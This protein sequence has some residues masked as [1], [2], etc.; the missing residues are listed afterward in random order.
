MKNSVATWLAAVGLSSNMAGPFWSAI[1]IL[2]LFLFCFIAHRLVVR[3]A[4]P[5]VV[6]AI[7][8]SK[9][10]MDDAILQYGV[11]PRLALLAPLVLFYT[12]LDLI[13]PAGQGIG[14]FGRRTAMVLFILVSVSTIARLLRAIHD[15]L[16]TTDFGQKRPLR[17]Y[18]DAVRITIFCLATI[19]AF[20]TITGTPPWG[21]LSFL[22]GFTVLLMLVFKDTILG[23]VASI[24]ISLNDTVRMGDWIQM[25]QF[26]ADGEIIDISIHA[27]KV[28][29]WDKTISV[30]PSYALTSQSF[31]NWRGMSES[32]G[33]RIKRSILIDITSIH[34]CNEELLA[35]LKKIFLLKDYLAGR[36]AEIEQY[37]AAVGADPSEPVNGRRLTNIGTFRAYVVAYL[38][39]HPQVHQEM[40]F[41]VR[42]LPPG[43]NGLPLEIYIFSKDQVWANYEAIQADIFD[44]LLAVLPRFDLRPFQNPT[45]MDFRTVSH[46]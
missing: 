10:T 25:D 44:H 14:E 29:N 45:G 22:G 19:F 5:L 9:T 15:A 3:L 7:R 38:R 32:G 42:H 24:Q 8:F 26:G 20:S 41:L 13:F 28:Q 11:L 43:P 30:I 1:L 21:I 16:R 35:R 2:L 23:F 27:V 17:G 31:K 34:F 46:G 37:N 6:R 40:T 33:R 36:L 18:I 4:L 12:G 39:N